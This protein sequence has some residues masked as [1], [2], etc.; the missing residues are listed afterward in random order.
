MYVSLAFRRQQI[1][2]IDKQDAV[3]DSRLPLGAARWRNRQNSIV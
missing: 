3:G 1:A 2:N